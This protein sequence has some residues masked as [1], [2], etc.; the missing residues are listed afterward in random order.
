[1]SIQHLPGH[2]GSSFNLVLIHGWGMHSGI[3]E[4]VLP[5]LK[6]HGDVWCVDLPGHGQS[7]DEP[8]PDTP[9]ATLD[10]VSDIAA[11]VPDNSIWLGWS[12]GG[13]FALQA[14]VSGFC[15]GLI[16]TACNPCFI[17]QPHWPEAMPDE[18]FRQFADDLADDYERT[19]RRFLALEVHG[20]EQAKAQLQTLQRIAFIHGAPAVSALHGGLDLLRQADFSRSLAD[21]NLPVLIIGGRRDRLVPWSGLEQTAQRLPNARLQRIPGAGHAPFIGDPQAF[22]AAVLEF[23]DEL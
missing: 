20:S 1:M 9:Q 16:L 8:W 22:A 21:L 13:L 17:Q 19:L 14:A 3:W 2:S 15:R 10:R 23:C 11:Q 7:Q 4:P 5:L 18:V 6:P 12:M